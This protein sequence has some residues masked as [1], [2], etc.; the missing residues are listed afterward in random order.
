MPIH[1]L[2]RERD[3]QAVS[4]GAWP[5]EMETGGVL[6]RVEAARQFAEGL[7]GGHFRSR[8]AG[9]FVGLSAEGPSRS[10]AEGTTLHAVRSY[11]PTMGRLVQD[12]QADRPAMSLLSTCR[13]YGLA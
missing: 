11:P 13:R 9:E 8:K 4:D 2:C 7:L 10:W 12:R 1:L 5:D 6:F 3:R